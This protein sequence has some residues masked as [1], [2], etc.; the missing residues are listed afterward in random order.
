MS[1]VAEPMSESVKPFTSPPTAERSKGAPM[2]TKQ[3]D[4]RSFFKISTLAGGGVMIGL[5]TGS[6]TKV[7]AQGRGGPGGGGAAA[8]NPNVYITINPDNTF[9]IVGKNPETGQ[10]M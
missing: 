4:R 6:A 1:A 7:F 3:L 2:N 5:Y 9:S 8:P 10:G